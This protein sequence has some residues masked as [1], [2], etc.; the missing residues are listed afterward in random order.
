MKDARARQF[1]E[2]LLARVR[3]EPGVDAAALADVL[4]LTAT[5]MS[6]TITT[7]GRPGPRYD[8]VHVTPDYFATLGTRI[9][10]GRAI[11]GE[12]PASGAPVAVVSA[13]LARTLFPGRS[14]VG[15]RLD[16]TGSAPT[17]VVGVAED[18]RQWQLE[19]APSPVA[20]V[21]MPHDSHWRYASLAIRTIG[22]SARLIP[23]IT[24]VVQELDPSQHQELVDQ[25]INELS[26]LN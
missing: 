6:V 23:A 11:E 10:E 19:A 26:G 3:R 16:A 24:R 15:Q 12:D 8:V 21:S 7:D 9:V 22:P 2:E 4:P 25:Y 13:T 17:T 14:A 5:R 20:F 18:V 1:M